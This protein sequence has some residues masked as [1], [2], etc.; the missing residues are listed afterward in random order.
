MNPTAVTPVKPLP[1]MTR[2]GIAVPVGVD[3]GEID[4]IVTLAKVALLGASGMTGGVLWPLESVERTCCSSMSTES[5]RLS[6]RTSR[7][8]KGIRSDRP[9]P[10]SPKSALV[11][12]GLITRSGSPKRSTTACSVS[13]MTTT[14]ENIAT[15]ARPIA[16]MLAL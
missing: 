15:S 7:S 9:A 11:R 4:V 5:K 2:D 13:G 10:V 6:T 8:A 12:N 1:L 16:T 3:V 14:L